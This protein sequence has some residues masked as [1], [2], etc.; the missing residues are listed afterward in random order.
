MVSVKILSAAGEKEGIIT[1]YSLIKINLKIYIKG[2]I[3][4]SNKSSL[5]AWADRIGSRQDLWYN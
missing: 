2:N 5:A 1:T 3:I 4:C